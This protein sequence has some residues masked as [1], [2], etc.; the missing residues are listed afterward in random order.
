MFNIF[1]KKK[2]E[3][4]TCLGYYNTKPYDALRYSL[5]YAK[6]ELVYED[7]QVLVFSRNYHGT[8]FIF[9][10]VNDEEGIVFENFT[11][12]KL[13]SMVY[14]AGIETGNSFI[15]I[16]VFQNNNEYTRGIA[17][18]PRINTKDEFNQV[19]VFNPDEV[20]LE[21]YRP[22]PNFYN[23]YNKFAE[24]IYYDLTAIDPEKD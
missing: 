4:L 19:L 22:V 7:N 1:K 18:E 20:R 12:S 11:V 5:A 9:T 15:N 16:M 3:S 24:A 21:Y 13:K 14:E 2:K 8:I 10:L 17:K 6:N 23:L